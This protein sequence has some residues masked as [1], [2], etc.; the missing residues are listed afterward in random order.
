MANKQKIIVFN[1]T[2]PREDRTSG[3]RRLVGILRILA[4]HHDVH[5]CISRF[6]EWL[7]SDEYQQ[8]VEKLEKDKIKVLPIK[9][10]ITNEVLSENNYDI[11]FFEFYWIAEEVL[12]IFRRYQ[13]GA[14]TL[15]DS[16]DVAFAREE[17][18][19]DLGLIDM[20][21][22]QETKLKELTVYQKADATIVVSDK[23]GD[24]LKNIDGISNIFLVPN[25]VPI[26]PR[27]RKKREP[28]V[29][30]IGC[31]L[32]PPN[33][34][35]VAW[36]VESIWPT[37][38]ENNKESEFLIIGSNPT[39][40]IKEMSKLPG[41]KVL[42]FVED[43][44]PYFDE[45]AV[46]VAPLRYGGGM[47]GK[48]NEALAH[49]IPVVTTSIGAQGF[50]AQNNI[51]MLIEDDPVKFAECVIRLI[52]DPNKQLEVGLAGQNLHKK[53]SSPDAV[54]KKIDLLFEK[55]EK[56]KIEKLN[57]QSML[58]SVYARSRTVRNNINKFLR[59][60]VSYNSYEN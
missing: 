24:I 55:T 50:G 45:A 51:D 58:K 60:K 38:Y 52:E 12:P 17:S 37:I 36:F 49:G 21:K 44:E 41:V 59:S 13:P 14:I 32:W 39:N 47:K 42:G 19:A 8:Y 9:E 11:G 26:F 54:E 2:I 46:S 40:E 48:I 16:V 4:K 56:L 3:D 7:L 28:K 31:Y 34:D 53:I 5:L 23:D 29:I 15:V 18:E 33:V 25:I 10:N 43:T 57:N 1:Y 20:S 6:G 35:G 27:N 30:F 22:A